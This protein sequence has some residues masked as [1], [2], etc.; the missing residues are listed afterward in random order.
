VIVS[1]RSIEL[2]FVAITSS[3]K[4]LVLIKADP[5]KSHR[6]VE[7]FRIALG[8]GSHNEGQDVRILLDGRA[9]HLLAEDLSNIVDAEILEKH[10]PVFL[11]WGTVFSIGPD[12]ESP[13]EYLPDAITKRVTT[14]EVVTALS[15]ADRVLVF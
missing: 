6:A 5:F 7:A 13:L 11:E 2:K 3:P 12:A 15:T 8:L 10:L 1:S 14:E 4:T 9:P